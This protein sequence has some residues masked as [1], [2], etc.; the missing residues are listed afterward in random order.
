MDEIKSTKHAKGSMSFVYMDGITHKFQDILDSRNLFDIIKY[1]N[2][3][4]QKA[5]NNVKFIVTDMN[6]TYPRLTQSV[7]P[8]ATVVTDRFHVVKSLNDAINQVRIRVMKQF[9]TST[10]EYRVLKKYWKLLLM[11]LAK[12]NF[13]LF[14]KYTGFDYLVTQQDVIDRMLGLNSELKQVY[15]KVHHIISTINRCDARELRTCI[16][17]KEDIPEELSRKLVYLRQNIDFVINSVIYP[18]SNGPLE[19]FNNIAKLFK[20]VAFGYRNFNNFRL[21]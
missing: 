16:L 13:E 12:I 7:F 8:N 18:Y 15:D 1:F 19:G 20:R 6:Y 17:D 10:K 14:R 3:F 2:R 11:P 5:R 21:R 9:G 4:D